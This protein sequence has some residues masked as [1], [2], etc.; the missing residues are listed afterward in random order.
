MKKI[1]LIFFIL[2]SSCISTENNTENY[3]LD[4]SKNMTFDEFGIKL[5]VYSEK[6][7]YPNIDN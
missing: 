1:F 3:N 7:P 4:F 5:K 6:S 2:L